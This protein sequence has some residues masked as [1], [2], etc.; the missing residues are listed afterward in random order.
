MLVL[1]SFIFMCLL[2]L[3]DVLIP[4]IYSL[5]IANI[6]IKARFIKYL[7]FLVVVYTAILFGLN[8]LDWHN[9]LLMP[10]FESYVRLLMTKM[11]IES[12]EKDNQEIQTGGIISKV[13]SIIP[14]YISW[15]I[16]LKDYLIPNAF[17]FIVATIYFLTVDFILGFVIFSVFSSLLVL[18]YKSP[19]KCAPSSHMT[20]KL[21]H[22][23]YEN[24][25][26][27]LRNLVSVYEGNQQQYELVRIN[28]L[29]ELFRVKY[30]ETMNCVISNKTFMVPLLLVLII[31]FAFRC[32]V[33]VQSKRMHLPLFVSIFMI[34]STL[35]GNLSL[36]IDIVKDINYSIGK[37]DD[38]ELRFD[39]KRTDNTTKRNENKEEN[40]Q[41]M[42]QEGIVFQNVSMSYNNI[43]PI[44][45]DINL[46]IIPYQIL[47]ITG[48]IGSGKT[49][50]TRLL[51]N[52]KQ[53]NVGSISVDGHFYSSLDRYWLNKVVRFVPQNPIL[54]DRSIIENIKY[55]NESLDDVKVI[56]FLK[57][58]GF[59]DELS[60]Y[61]AGLDTRVGKN[62]TNVSGGQRQ[63][64]WCLRVLLSKPK[65]IVLDEPTASMDQGTKQKLV[66]LFHQFKHA[67]TFIIITHDEFV[68]SIAER[69]VKLEKGRIVYDSSLF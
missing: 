57:E 5:I 17:V 21:T 33:L 1:T 13:S 2:P 14:W 20:A 7:I 61:E 62:G 48:S 40:L 41:V 54:F 23:I 24:M 46:H 68:M 55:G 16:K 59:Y 9:S 11:I 64:I 67:T 29:E 8:A 31:V 6:T 65:Y 37:V 28:R 10:K 47:V 22:D 51:M 42:N 53:P 50:L 60:K 30:K 45:D 43:K 19:K 52:V 15:F 58:V 35:I 32:F 3:Y 38:L 36:I 44:L 39:S 18:A 69:L 49:T 27:V 4:Y 26:D 56:E 25:D 34:F 12:N 63:V 66:R